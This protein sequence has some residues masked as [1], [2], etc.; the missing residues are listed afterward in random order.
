MKIG[1]VIGHNERQ[2]GAVRTTDG[3]TEYD[4]NGELA[5]AILAL[6]PDQVRVFRREWNPRGY[7]AEIGEVYAESDEWGADVTA[8]LHFNGSTDT[9]AGG[10]E[11]W[12]ATSAGKAVAEKV[13]AGMMSALGLRDR[14][15]KK[16]GSEQNGYMSLIS[17]RAPAVLLEPFFGSNALDSL[18]ADQSRGMLAYAIFNALSGVETEKPVSDPLTAWLDELDALM[19]RRP[20]T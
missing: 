9:A 2:Q 16:A 8:E 19:A 15:I 13:Q 14:G 10:T 5:G 12:Y 1:I 4:W 6:S 7:R 11:T 20:K 3:R 18:R 17:G